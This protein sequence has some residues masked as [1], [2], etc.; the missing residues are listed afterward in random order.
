[1]KAVRTGRV[2]FA[3]GNL[4]FNRAGTTIARTAEILAEILHG[5]ETSGLTEGS[6]W[7]WYTE[8]RV[9]VV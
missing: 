9:R 1:M 6:C 2:A 8:S 4:Y 5:V 7:R 3:D